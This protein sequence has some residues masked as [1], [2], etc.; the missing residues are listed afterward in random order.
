MDFF[1]LF[2]CSSRPSLSASISR[3]VAKDAGHEE[4]LT[5]LRSLE[6]GLERMGS[7]PS[8]TLYQGQKL[9]EFLNL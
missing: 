1:V 8:V 4:Y 2:I 6:E 7:G 5:F 9:Y 3:L